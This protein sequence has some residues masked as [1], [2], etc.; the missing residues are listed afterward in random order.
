MRG[1]QDKSLPSGVPKYKSMTRGL[2]ATATYKMTYIG[3]NIP[4]PKFGPGMFRHQEMSDNF[5]QEIIATASQGSFPIAIFHCYPLK[6]VASR[7]HHIRKPSFLWPTVHRHKVWRLAA[8]TPNGCGVVGYLAVRRNAIM[9]QENPGYETVSGNFPKLLPRI[10]LGAGDRVQDAWAYFWPFSFLK[11]HSIVGDASESLS[12]IGCDRLVIGWLE[13]AKR[14]GRSGQSDW[15]RLKNR[16]GRRHFKRKAL[17][18]HVYRTS[19]RSNEAWLPKRFEL[20]AVIARSRPYNRPLS[21]CMHKRSGTPQRLAGVWML[22]LPCS[23][24]GF[25]VHFTTNSTSPN[26]HKWECDQR[27]RPPPQKSPTPLVAGPLG[28]HKESPRD[29]M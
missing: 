11:F 22:A 4:S 2:T 8:D 12:D 28:Q 5:G 9:S 17:Q 26:T 25:D 15:T 24:P 21:G 23:G 10:L 14:V 1:G 6:M 18:G 3:K 13:M 19:L 29:K 27:M 16:A 20:L 7:E